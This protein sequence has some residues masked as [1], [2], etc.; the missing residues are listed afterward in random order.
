MLC[1]TL[2]PDLEGSQLTV[3][4]DTSAAAVRG[5]NVMS[6]SVEVQRPKRRM[7]GEGALLGGVG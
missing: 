1:V 5:G 2:L 6:V 7:E 4:K 3:Q